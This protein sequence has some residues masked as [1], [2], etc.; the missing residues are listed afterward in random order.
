M[1]VTSPVRFALWSPTEE[2]HLH[3]R[4]PF[5]CR[6]ISCEFLTSLQFIA[7]TTALP[8]EWATKGVPTKAKAYMMPREEE[9][10]DS[11]GCAEVL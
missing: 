3:R 10:A 11:I 8:D 7:R 2:S 4:Q 9:E 1:S 6:A 5:L